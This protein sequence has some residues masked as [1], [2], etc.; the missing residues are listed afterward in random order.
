MSD[1]EALI[2]LEQKID[3]MMFALQS[4]GIM[5]KELP[6]LE[7]LESDVCALCATPVSLVI[8]TQNGTLIRNCGCKLPKKAFK[9]TLITEEHGNANTRNQKS[10][11]PPNSPEPDS[12]GS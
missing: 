4:A 6:Q 7:G 9:L 2:R 11:I 3:T 1:N 10:E 5:L 8:D 12:S